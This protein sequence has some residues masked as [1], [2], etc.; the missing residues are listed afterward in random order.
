LGKEFIGEALRNT[1]MIGRGAS[2]MRL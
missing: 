1:L 2:I